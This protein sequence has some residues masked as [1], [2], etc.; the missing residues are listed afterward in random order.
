MLGSS[1]YCWSWQVSTNWHS[2]YGWENAIFVHQ[3]QPR[4]VAQFEQWFS[5]LNSCA[6]SNKKAKSSQDSQLSSS[7]CYREIL[8]SFSQVAERAL[9]LNIENRTH[10]LVLIYFSVVKALTNPSFSEA[11][12][13]QMRMFISS[14]PLRMYLLSADHLTQM[15]C[16]MRL[17]WYTSLDKMYLQNVKNNTISALNKASWVL[18]LCTT[19]DIHRKWHYFDNKLYT[20]HMYRQQNLL[21]RYMHWQIQWFEFKKLLRSEKIHLSVAHWNSYSTCIRSSTTE[22]VFFKQQ[23]N[24]IY[25]SLSPPPPHVPLMLHKDPLTEKFTMSMITHIF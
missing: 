3:I 8:K 13:F 6:L 11:L 7:L 5:Y 25:N 19:I 18:R 17:V 1:Y 12:A 4:T 22:G 2:N 10:Q 23:F 15:T 21:L 16:C 14:E 20:V 9:S 24:Y